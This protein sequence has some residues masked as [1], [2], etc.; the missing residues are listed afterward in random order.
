MQYHANHVTPARIIS[1]LALIAAVQ[2]GAVASAHARPHKK[3]ARPAAQRETAAPRAPSP[4]QELAAL[5]RLVDGFEYNEA[6]ELGQSLIARGHLS[7]S[8]LSEAQYLTGAAA[9]IIGDPDTAQTLFIELLKRE[10]SFALPEEAE[11]KVQAPF[12]AAEA[13]VQQ[14]RLELEARERAALIAAMRINGGAQQADP[15]GGQTL[16]FGFELADPA[17]SAVGMD[18]SFRHGGESAYNVLPLE[19]TPTGGWT[20]ELPGQ[21]TSSSEDYVLEYYVQSHAADGSPLVAMGSATSPIAINVARGRFET[22]RPFYKSPWF[23]VATAVGVASAGV[24][25]Y[26]IL[27]NS[28]SLP[29]TDLGTVTIE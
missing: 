25:T 9:A 26:L 29:K 20:G 16:A 6:L 17:A 11:P 28:S 18:L 21:L 14:E 3:R 2:T 23:W 15:T 22:H 7:A 19:R 8:A 24:A 10:P 4:E 5:R 27:H 13:R 12:H 1:T